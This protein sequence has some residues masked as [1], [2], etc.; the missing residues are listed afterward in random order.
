MRFLPDETVEHLRTVAELPDLSGT[1]YRIEREVARGGMGVIYLAEDEELARP[2]AIKVLHPLLSG[3]EAA[4]R[5]EREARILARLDH[6][7]IVPVHEVGRL[8]D[9]RVFYAMKLVRGSSLDDFAPTAPVNDL[10]RIFLRVCE[11]VAFAHAHG[12]I[13]R[14]LKPDNVM[15]GQFGE[16]LVMDWGVAKTDRPE[17]RE[18]NAGLIPPSRTNTAAGTIMGTPGYMSPEQSR[19]EVDTIDARSDVYSLGAILRFLF[20]PSE[21]AGTSAAQ[22]EPGSSPR[23]SPTVRVPRAIASICRRAMAEQKENRYASAGEL[24]EDI[25]RFLDGKAVEA[26]RENVLEKTARWISR[27]RLAVTVVAAY[28]VMRLL[29]FL[30]AGR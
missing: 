23:R 14:D 30:W 4:A 21:S 24:A 8:S 7:G 10:L 6:P 15:V 29:L 28:L 13:H 18:L 22:T 26:H 12:I 3:P 5:M 25:T 2:V 9:G 27:H 11:A 1:R 20:A 16:V 19:G 17:S